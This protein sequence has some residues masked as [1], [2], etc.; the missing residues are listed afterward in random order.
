MVLSGAVT[1]DGPVPAYCN[2]AVVLGGMTAHHGAV[3]LD[4]A[5]PLNDALP[6]NGMMALD[7]AVALDGA[8]A[9]DGVVALSSVV[10]HQDEN[11]Q[12]VSEPPSAS[13]VPLGYPPSLLN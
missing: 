13:T 4:G 6:L 1:L 3:A 8:I 2:G 10:G 9:L 12:I 11:Q 5:V 7:S